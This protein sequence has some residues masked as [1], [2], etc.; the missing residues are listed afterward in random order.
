[1]NPTDLRIVFA[2]TPAFA[3]AHLEALLQAG[4]QVV[5]VYSQPDRPAGRGK[6]LQPTAVK[7]VAEAHGL[8]V[9]QPL[10]LQDESAFAELAAW[11]PD[12]LVVVA[13]G[14]LLPPRVLALPGLGCLNVHTS[15]LPRWRGAAPI[16][17]ALMAGDAETGVSIM[18]MDEGLDTGPVLHEVR[19]PITSKDTSESL[20]Q[21]LCLLGCQALLEVLAALPRLREQARPQDPAQATYA[22]KIRKE[23]AELDW[24]R[25]AAELDRLARALFPRAPVFTWHAGQRL[26]LLATEVLPAGKPAAPG[27]VLA[28]TAA[29]IDVACGE[30]VLR[31]R[32]VQAEGRKAMSVAAM[33]NGH[34]GFLKPGEVLGGPGA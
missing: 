26:R 1:M 25:P 29:G 4:L 24:Q 23:E 2:G 9:C 5:S 14:L 12:V 30:G 34:P 8:P 11:R 17:R 19:T 10:S 3:A 21:R 32:E 20:G 27:T 22:A 31:A 18:L 15:L 28:C 7:A 6:K 13:Y 33:L 16:E